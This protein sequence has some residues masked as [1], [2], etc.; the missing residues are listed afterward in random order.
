V[1]FVP[2]RFR[3]GVGVAAGFNG[4]RTG[5]QRWGPADDASHSTSVTMSPARVP[6]VSAVHWAAQVNVD[7]RWSWRLVLV[8]GSGA[9]E[10]SVAQNDPA[11]VQDESFMFN[12]GGLGV[13]GEGPGSALGDHSRS[14]VS[15]RGKEIADPV[16]ADP[17]C[18]TRF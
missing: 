12:D 8:E 2:E 13:I 14:G 10:L 16:A 1:D 3:C 7:P 17:D 5:Q 18:A 4:H 9:A 6:S 11:G 15:V